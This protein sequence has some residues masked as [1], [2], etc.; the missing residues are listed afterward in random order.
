MSAY[1]LR[2][3][4]LERQNLSTAVIWTRK[5]AESAKRKH[6]GQLGRRKKVFGREPSITALEAR[7]LSQQETN[8]GGKNHQA[9]ARQTKKYSE[10]A[11]SKCPG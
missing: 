6:P 3:G 9:G 5:G 8:Y 11:G 1:M 10:A 4:R 7:G 2:S